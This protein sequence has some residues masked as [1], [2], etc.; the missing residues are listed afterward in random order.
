M[1]ISITRSI[2]G[3][4]KIPHPPDIVRAMAI[5]KIITLL[6]PEPEWQA[7]IEQAVQEDVKKEKSIAITLARGDVEIP[8]EHAKSIAELLVITIATTLIEMLQ[9]K[10]LIEIINL[11]PLDNAVVTAIRESIKKDSP[12]P[13]LEGLSPETSSSFLTRHIIPAALLAAIEERANILSVFEKMKVYRREAYGRK[14][15]VTT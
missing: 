7:L 14:S 10:S 5:A 4:F 15:I 11:A 6:N 9:N 12:L 13:F 8:I 2:E 1:Q 3:S